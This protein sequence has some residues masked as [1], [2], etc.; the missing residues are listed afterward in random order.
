M[1]NTSS[2]DASKLSERLYGLGQ[3]EFW[4]HLEAASMLEKYPGVYYSPL[5]DAS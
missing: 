1:A 2:L 3:E 5:W 4:L